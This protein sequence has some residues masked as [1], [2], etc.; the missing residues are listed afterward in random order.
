MHVRAIS[1][2]YTRERADLKMMHD[3]NN[4]LTDNEIVI[5][6]DSSKTSKHA[7]LYIQNGDPRGF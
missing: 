1:I 3:Q 6:R 7:F 5:V 4:V 2:W